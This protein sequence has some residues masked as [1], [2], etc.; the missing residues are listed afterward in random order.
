ML[1]HDGCYLGFVPTFFTFGNSLL[2]CMYV[3]IFTHEIS[4]ASA[5]S[6][7]TFGGVV[8]TIYD[9]AR[10]HHTKRVGESSAR[11][12]R[13]AFRCTFLHSQT[14]SKATVFKY[15]EV[16]FCISEL[17]RAFL[18]CF[19]SWVARCPFRRETSALE[20]LPPML[21]G[22]HRFFTSVSVTRGSMQLRKTTANQDGAISFALNPFTSSCLSFGAC[23]VL[24][25]RIS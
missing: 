11:A 7:V 24:I 17:F 10:Q 4:D 6:D 20:R 22:L 21:P 14:T 2:A 18:F 9:S 8:R 13:L 19:L 23:V 12:C 1:C 5:A 15:R 16:A 25:P 3:I